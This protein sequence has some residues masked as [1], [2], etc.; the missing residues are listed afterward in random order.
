MQISTWKPQNL[1]GVQHL[2]SSSLLQFREYRYTSITT[3]IC[4]WLPAFSTQ[5]ASPSSKA[6]YNF[7]SFLTPV[8]SHGWGGTSSG[9]LDPARFPCIATGTL[10]KHYPFA[11]HFS[12]AIFLVFPLILFGPWNLL[13]FLWPWVG[14]EGTFSWSLKRFLTTIRSLILDPWSL[15]S[16]VWEQDFRKF[17]IFRLYIHEI[18]AEFLR[19]C[20]MLSRF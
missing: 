10:G 18:L 2:D 13:S 12:F 17:D 7:W 4:E 15:I 9:Y 3:S 20:R 6:R 11:F 16:R 14:A 5:N 19:K 1:W 8:L